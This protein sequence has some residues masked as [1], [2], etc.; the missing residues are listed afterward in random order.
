M[1]KASLRLC[2]KVSSAVEENNT[3]LFIF[4]ASLL[5]FPLEKKKKNRCPPRLDDLVRTTKPG[6]ENVEVVMRWHAAAAAAK[7]SGPIA[8]TNDVITVGTNNHF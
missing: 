5:Q 8:H 7:I 4:S 1:E 3:V 2:S 6:G